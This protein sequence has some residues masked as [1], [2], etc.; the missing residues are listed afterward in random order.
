MS[1][2]SEIKTGLAGLNKDR[3]TLFKFALTFCVVF[4]LLGIITLLSDRSQIMPFLFIGLSIVFFL[5][6]YFLPRS[7]KPLYA[8]WMGLAFFLGYFVSRILLTLLFYILITP[9]SIILK[10][11]GKDILDEKIE[12]NKTTY[13]KKKESQPERFEKMY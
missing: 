11:F 4:L 2:I 10:I 13:W 6:G 12:K 5:W 8:L 3:K 9:I 1:L 7:L